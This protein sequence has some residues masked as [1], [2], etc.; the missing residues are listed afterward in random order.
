MSNGK[1]D[2]SFWG[3]S[4]GKC[5]FRE[6]KGQRTNGGCSCVKSLRYSP[7]IQQIKLL[8][9]RAEKLEAVYEAAKKFIDEDS[10]SDLTDWEKLEKAIKEVGD[11]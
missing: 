2:Y 11:D 6:N 4:D 7:A 8:L 10:K 3:C 5:S 1:P 9:N